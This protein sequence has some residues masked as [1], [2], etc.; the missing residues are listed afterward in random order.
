MET[1]RVHISFLDL[2]STELITTKPHH[3]NADEVLIY[4]LYLPD[5][6]ELKLDLCRFLRKEEKDRAEQF[7]KEIDK[8][9]FI[10]YRSILKFVLASHTNLDVKH[11]CLD[12]DVNKKPFLA[13]HPFLYFNIS[14]SEDFAVIAVSHKKVGIDIEYKSENFNFSNLFPD[15]F[16][17]KEMHAIQNA[18]DKQQTFYTF[19]TRKEAFAKGLGKGI[20][21]DFKYIPCLDGQQNLNPALFTNNKNW[22]ICSFVFTNTYLAAVAFESN[23]ATAE[24]IILYT[25][26]N[27][28]KSLLELTQVREKT[29]FISLDN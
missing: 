23:T 10:I 15:I 28:M 26:P 4:T 13:S 18:T 17:D 21:E 20:D 27:S 3:L 14:H 25:I 5:F 8:N 19:W 2:K 22:Q 11:I 1:A 12:Y 16:D 9:R 6:I 29:S 24:N 7:Y